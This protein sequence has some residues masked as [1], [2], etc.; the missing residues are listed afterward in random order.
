[1][2]IDLFIVSLGNRAMKKGYLWSCQL[3]QAGIRTEI[4]FRGKSLKALMKRANKLNAGH[5]LIVGENELDQN[6][7]IL[8]DMN[9]KVQVP[10]DIDTLVDD[11]TEKMIKKL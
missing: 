5:V 7:A 11:L 2:D 6:T 9:T 4:D 10:I 8:R 3:N 1:K